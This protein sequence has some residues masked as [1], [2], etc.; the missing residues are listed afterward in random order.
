M[1]YASIKS[2]I[3]CLA[4]S[5]VF[6]G[7]A[8]NGICGQSRLIINVDP[9]WRFHLDPLPVEPTATDY[10]DSGWDIVS[11]PH[12]HEVFTANLKGFKQAGRTV[13]W[14]RRELDVSEE[15]LKKKVFLEFRGAMQTTSL[16]VNGRPV[17]NYAVSGF[18]SFDFDMRQK[19]QSLYFAVLALH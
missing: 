11:L 19:G 12:T 10:D 7:T 17:G 16:W 3:A 1:Q 8:S 14:Y 4:L 2:A 18:D 9:V 13:G 6:A 5:A 15:W